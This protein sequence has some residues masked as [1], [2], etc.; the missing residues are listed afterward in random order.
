[1]NKIID[2]DDDFSSINTNINKIKTEIDKQLTD[3]I[4]DNDEIDKI[5]VILI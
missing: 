1:M 2:F 5:I 3:Q 4:S